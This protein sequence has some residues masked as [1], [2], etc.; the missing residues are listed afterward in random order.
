MAKNFQ[1]FPTFSYIGA[2][3]RQTFQ[4]CA[5]VNNQPPAC[6]PVLI[7]WALY[8]NGNGAA[9]GAQ[10]GVNINLLVGGVKPPIA[11]IECVYID[12]SYS[13]IPV[14]IS[15]PDTGFV[16]AAG[17]NQIVMV[18]VLTNV[19]QCTIYA[20]G[21]DGIS[22]PLT[23]VLLMDK[24]VAQY[25]V[26]TQAAAVTQSVVTNLSRNQSNSGASS[27]ASQAIGP[28][29]LRNMVL[30]VGRLQ[31]FSGSLPPITNPTLGGISGTFIS[32]YDPGTG[33]IC[34]LPAAQFRIDAWKFTLSASDPN[35]NQT[36]LWTPGGAAPYV[37]F[38]LYRMQF[39]KSLTEQFLYASFQAPVS[40]P[41]NVAA[42]SCALGYSIMIGTSGNVVHGSGSSVF[43]TDS[44]VNLS[45]DRGANGPAWGG[46]NTDFNALINGGSCALAGM[47]MFIGYR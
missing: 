44:N 9:S 28:P 10:T 47:E 40:F 33:N 20:E 7:N 38:S 1:P 14:Y 27:F 2:F 37:G 6:A 32:S 19:L 25:V 11:K 21:F 24:Y 46:I 3:Y 16:A 5:P 18:P 31:T 34:G 4:V 8:N 22:V 39:L 41:T 43:P 17:A 29:E 26:S 15:F 12:N 30:F 35:G 36:I 42:G 23:R 13:N 45:C